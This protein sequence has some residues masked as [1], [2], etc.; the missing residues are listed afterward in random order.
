MDTR[1]WLCFPPVDSEV[2]LLNEGKSN[3]GVRANGEARWRELVAWGP[4]G[5]ENEHPVS[6]ADLSKEKEPFLR[7]SGPGETVKN[8]HPL[9][10]LRESSFKKHSYTSYATSTSSSNELLVAKHFTKHTSYSG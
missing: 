5:P 1:V 2:I 6:G 4:R 10:I 9:R 8:K 7:H 3:K